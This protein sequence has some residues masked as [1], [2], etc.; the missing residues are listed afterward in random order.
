MKTAILLAVLFVG[1][2]SL[3]VAPSLEA[4]E[5]QDHNVH[6]AGAW[7]SPT[8]DATSTRAQWVS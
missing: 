6:P 5:I 3:P 7:Q 8:V 4:K 1:T 2:S